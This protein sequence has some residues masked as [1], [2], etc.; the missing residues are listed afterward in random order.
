MRKLLLPVSVALLAGCLS[1]VG[2]KEDD[3]IR[4]QGPDLVDGRGEVF[5]IRGVNLGN[6]LLPEGYMFGFGTCNSAHFIDEMFRQLVGVEATRAFWRAFKD[7]YVTEADIARLASLGINTVRVPF[8]YKLFT[9]EDYMDLTGPGDGFRRFDDVIGWCRRYG[10]KVILDMHACPGGNT[11]DNIDDSYAYPQLF[12]SEAAQT[13]YAEIWRRIAARYADEPTV[14]GYDLM[15]EPIAH[16]YAN[17]DDLNLRLEAVQFKAI[18]AIR[19]VDR[20]HVVILAGGQWNTNFYM[21]RDFEKDPNMMYTCHCY[22]FGQPAFDDAPLVKFAAFRDKV[23][24]PMYMGETGHNVPAWCVA[25]VKSM[26]EK[27]IGWTFWPYKMPGHGGWFNFSFPEGWKEMVSAFAD[28][29]RSSYAKI[30][31]HRPDRATA[32][33]LMDAFLTNCRCENAA[34]DVDYLKALGLIPCEIRK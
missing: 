24:R 5:R 13:Q 6:W 12:E 4:V 29:D 32:R 20:R 19:E 22:Q 23:N 16:H 10:L 7:S 27:N 26:N 25:I 1:V 34:A 9:D 3:F 21:Y 15:N 30:R 8:S 33:R 11:G 31:E 28:A 14:L 2:P 18:D 17:A